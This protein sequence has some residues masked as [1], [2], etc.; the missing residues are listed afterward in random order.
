MG[1]GKPQTRSA[2]ETLLGTASAPEMG[3]GSGV[4][5]ALCE[6]EVICGSFRKYGLPYFGVLIIRILLFGVLRG[7]YFRKPCLNRQGLLLYSLFSA[8][9]APF[10]V[11]GC[12]IGYKAYDILQWFE[13]DLWCALMLTVSS[14]ESFY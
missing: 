10:C 7:S 13:N 12:I 8:A 1:D 9:S 6:K 11:G 4:R 2:R 14:R 5:C 3:I